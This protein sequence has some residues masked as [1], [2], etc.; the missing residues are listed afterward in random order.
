M[1]P[2]Q[3]KTVLRV[4]QNDVKG[5]WFIQKKSKDSPGWGLFKESQFNV[6]QWAEDIVNWHV[7]NFP[8][9]YEREE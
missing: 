7:D 1:K 6:R 9:Q 2:K 3:T 4:R 5:T 8:K